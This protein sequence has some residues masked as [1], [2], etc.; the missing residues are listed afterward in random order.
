[1]QADELHSIAAMKKVKKEPNM[2]IIIIY[3][4]V[5]ERSLCPETL[6]KATRVSVLGIVLFSIKTHEVITIILKK[7]KVFKSFT[8][9]KVRILKNYL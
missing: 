5:K 4:D 3:R 8:L 7:R 1:L 2:N 6:Q 9:R